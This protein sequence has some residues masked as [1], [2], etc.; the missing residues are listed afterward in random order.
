MYE[1]TEG[2]TKPSAINKMDAR[3]RHS[4]RRVDEPESES[5]HETQDPTNEGAT[6]HEPAVAY[7]LQD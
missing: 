2:K 7:F 4:G 5:M 1:Q 3:K 6:A